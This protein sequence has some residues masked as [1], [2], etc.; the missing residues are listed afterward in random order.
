MIFKKGKI[1]KALYEKGTLE[2]T[3][4]YT[5]T[6][7]LHWYLDSLKYSTRLENVK[8]VFKLSLGPKIS[9]LHRQRSVERL[10]NHGNLSGIKCT[11]HYF[12]FPYISQFSLS[13]L[14]ANLANRREEKQTLL[15][16]VGCDV[17]REFGEWL[18]DWSRS[19]L[20]CGLVLLGFPWGSC[21]GWW[22]PPE[23]LQY[24]MY[25][26]CVTPSHPQ[27]TTKVKPHIIW[28]CLLSYVQPHC[29]Q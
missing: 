17:R 23:Q 22:N 15:L 10:R 1:K 13:I 24:S 5:G 2:S 20:G 29:L 3:S 12:I 27:C 7:D 6:R 16:N 19:I 11:W 18:Q 8:H 4:T 9:R 21:N 25:V 14:R 26:F 28:W